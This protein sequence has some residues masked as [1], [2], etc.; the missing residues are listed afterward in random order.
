MVDKLF[1]IICPEMYNNLPQFS[2]FNSKKYKSKISTY[3]ESN[4]MCYYNQMYI[5]EIYKI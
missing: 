4:K 1:V 5:K 3:I 2:I